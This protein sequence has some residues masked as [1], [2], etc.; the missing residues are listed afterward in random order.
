VHRAQQ[1]RRLHAQIGRRIPGSKEE[2]EEE[3][4]QQQQQQQAEEAK[5][6]EEQQQAEEE[7]EEEP[8]RS[9]MLMRV[10]PWQPPLQKGKK[11]LWKWRRL[12][13]SMC[14]M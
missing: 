1:R 10:R 11:L 3:E 12:N 7:E 14:R 13:Y 6:E 4:Q 9:V 2:E 8:V 5:A